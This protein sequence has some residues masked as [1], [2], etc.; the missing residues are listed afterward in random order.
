M[1]VFGG[2]LILIV[3]LAIPVFPFVLAVG[4]GKI[5]WLLLSG[6]IVALYAIL[7]HGVRKDAPKQKHKENYSEGLTYEEY[8]E[9]YGKPDD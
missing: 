7:W 3:I 4:T 8:V 2:L 6:A 1:K 9:K 5:G